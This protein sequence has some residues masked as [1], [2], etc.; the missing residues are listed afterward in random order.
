MVNAP[1]TV[2]TLRVATSLLN[3]WPERCCWLTLVTDSQA[4][5]DDREAFLG[6]ND[7]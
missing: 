1:S 4:V 7:H 5:H 6:D 3:L 2:D